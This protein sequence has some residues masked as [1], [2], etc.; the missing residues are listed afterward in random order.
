MDSY[1]VAS[2]VWMRRRLWCGGWVG[3]GGGN[4]KGVRNSLWGYGLERGS[5]IVCIQALLARYR[6]LLETGGTKPNSPEA[7]ELSETVMLRVGFPPPSPSPAR[8]LQGRCK[9]LDRAS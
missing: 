5:Q 4:L 9:F 3:G 7:L 6:R 1:Q 8:P 2:G